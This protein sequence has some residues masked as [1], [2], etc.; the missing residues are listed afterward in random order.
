MLVDAWRAAES[1]LFVNFYDGVLAR[2]LIAAGQMDEA[3]DRIAIA[4]S[5]AEETDAKFYYAELLRLRAMT[6]A[7]SDSRAT[8]LAE[9]I[10]VARK[11][12]AFIFELRAAID[13][14]DLR[15]DDARQVLI[16]AVGRFDPDST[17]PELAR[18]RTLLG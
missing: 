12:R 11:Q 10:V 2:L 8:D 17:W 7:D 1:K 14:F 18:A 5:L 15:A 9:A 6:A 4:L 3:R 16:D 13:D